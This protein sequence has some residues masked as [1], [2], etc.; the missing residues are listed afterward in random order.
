[1]RNGEGKST[2]FGLIPEKLELMSP[3][4][5]KGYANPKNVRFRD[6]LLIPTK[7][8]TDKSNLWA[9]SSSTTRIFLIAPYYSGMAPLFRFGDGHL[10]IEAWGGGIVALAYQPFSFNDKVVNTL[11]PNNSFLILIYGVLIIPLTLYIKLLF[12]I[13]N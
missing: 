9:A 10:L 8:T 1:M 11:F 4:I 5:F 6:C 13:T 3:H 7:R 12:L 2:I